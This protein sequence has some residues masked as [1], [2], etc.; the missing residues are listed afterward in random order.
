MNFLQDNIYQI[1]SDWVHCSVFKKENLAIVIT[2]YC[3]IEERAVE[4]RSDTMKQMAN[5][6]DHSY[7]TLRSKLTA[8]L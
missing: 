2:I 6:R 8:A 4:M 5:G 3:Y 7:P 1:T